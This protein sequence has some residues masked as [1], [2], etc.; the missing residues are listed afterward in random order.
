M[1]QTAK[2]SIKKPNEKELKQ[3]NPGVNYLESDKNYFN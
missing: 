2:E 3:H 1:K